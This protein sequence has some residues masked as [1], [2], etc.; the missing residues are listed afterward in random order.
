[1]AVLIKETQA[2]RELKMKMDAHKN[3]KELVEKQFSAWDGSHR[4]L[5]IL[6]K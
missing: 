3:R 2:E 5:T 1:M 4:G 6:I